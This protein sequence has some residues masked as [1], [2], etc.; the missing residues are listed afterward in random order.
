MNETL[1][2]FLL[3]ILFVVGFGLS[4][5][6]LFKIDNH[7]K[8]KREGTVFGTARIV[9]QGRSIHLWEI[10]VTDENGALVSLCKLT[11]MI[12]PRRR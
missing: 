9:H 12:L 4:M 1:Q 8:S 5:F 3:I 10:R 2:T 6:E 11:N 7:L